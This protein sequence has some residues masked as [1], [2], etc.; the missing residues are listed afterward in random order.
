MNS[1]RIRPLSKLQWVPVPDPRDLSH[2]FAWTTDCIT[3][4][5]LEI[6]QDRHGALFLVDPMVDSPPVLMCPVSQAE[7][8]HYIA[9]RWLPPALRRRLA[10][11]VTE[12]LLDDEATD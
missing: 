8:W 11:G 9:R 7:A 1:A 12:C 6:G 2:G 5:P 3:I 4:R 10:S